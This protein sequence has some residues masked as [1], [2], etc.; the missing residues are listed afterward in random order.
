MVSPAVSA[1]IRPSNGRVAA[2]FARRLPASGAGSAGPEVPSQPMRLS[3]AR[4]ARSVSLAR[5][6]G[7]CPL[8][9]G[10]NP[11]HGL[12]SAGRQRGAVVHLV[13]FGADSA[14]RST[15]A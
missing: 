11:D 9:T 8:G 7:L 6:A 14:D 5:A 13:V 4:R 3:L 2:G 10:G 1:G 12:A 15:V